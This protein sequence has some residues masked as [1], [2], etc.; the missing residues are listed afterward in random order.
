MHIPILL[1]FGSNINTQRIV[2][3]SASDLVPHVVLLVTDLERENAELK[4]HLKE[5]EVKQLR[6]QI[7]GPNRTPI[8]Y[9]GS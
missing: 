8:H 7:T 2:I 1:L 4:S 6:V 9:E 3:M 5:Q